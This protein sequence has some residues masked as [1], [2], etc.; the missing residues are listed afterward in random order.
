MA[1]ARI[2]NYEDPDPGGEGTWY[3][4][5]FV[6]R[7]L[8]FRLPDVESVA[9]MFG[10]SIDQLCW[11][12][13]YGN[14]PLSPFWY[15]KL[16]SEEV[17]RK[18]ADR[19]MLTRGL[20]EVWG[21][22]ADWSAL[23]AD[24]LSRPAAQREP[25]MRE[26][27]TF[28]VVM[29]A[30]GRSLSMQEQ[31]AEIQK[32]AFLPFKGRVDLKKPQVKLWLVMAGASSNDGIPGEVPDRL[33]L[34]RE[35]ALSNRSLL[36][37]YSLAKRAYIGPTSMDCEM[38][39][40]MANMAKVNRGQLVLD[41][42][43]GTGSILIAM[44]HFGAQVMGTDIDIKVIKRGRKDSGGRQVDLYSNFEQY[45]LTGRLG[46]LLRLD[47]HTCPFRPGIEEI[48]HAI[49][50]D[51][52]YGVRAGG[53]KSVPKPEVEIRDRSTH[54]PSTDPYTLGE[55]LRDLLDFAARTL[56]VGGRLVYFFPASVEDYQE[57]EIPTHPAL[58]LIANTEQNLTRR[59]S[60]RLMTMQK[61][62]KYDAAAAAAHHAACGDPILS[63]DRLH[64]VVYEPRMVDAEATDTLSID[65]AASVPQAG[66]ERPGKTKKYASKVL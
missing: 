31:V 54:I 57:S 10:C 4:C 66:S 26:D 38:A 59:Y 58:T 8:N 36:G 15:L 49:V 19:S 39:F 48:F 42:Y 7:F 12:R 65:S 21:E 24:I 51:P 3:L 37:T 1:R 47:L 25:W 61:V 13:P 60:R 46:G 56:L 23:Q 55:C 33:Y 40:L 64:D 45:N 44:A 16:P 5:H 50:G 30:Y 32:L 6:L 9:E 35:V 11:R 43:A 29:D 2:L 52:P 22:G 28:R 41:P 63:I 27:Q 20:F 62:N 53:R 18:V 34:C 14:D 17:A